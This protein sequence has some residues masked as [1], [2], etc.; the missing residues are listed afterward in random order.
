MYRVQMVGVNEIQAVTVFTDGG[1]MNDRH[2][3]KRTSRRAEMNAPVRIEKC[4][5]VCRHSD[6]RNTPQPYR[7]RRKFDECAGVYRMAMDLRS[8]HH[9]H[10]IAKQIGTG[11]RKCSKMHGNETG[12]PETFQSAVD[13]ERTYGARC[14]QETQ[15]QTVRDKLPL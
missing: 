10:A 6:Q 1:R 15:R 4:R 3:R 5:N 7:N 11:E 2:R 14:V 13:C 12:T 8:M 9:R